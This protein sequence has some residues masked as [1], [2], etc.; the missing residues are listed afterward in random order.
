MSTHEP[1]ELPNASTGWSRHLARWRRSLNKP[2]RH[3][4]ASVAHGLQRLA[5]PLTVRWHWLRAR[6]APPRP[7]G[8]PGELVLSLTS[9]PGR[10][11]VLHLTLMSLLGQ[12]VKP[13]HVVL[14]VDEA[15]ADLVPPKVRSLQDHGLSIRTWPQDIKS[16]MKIIPSLARWPEATFVTA[17]DDICYWPTWLEELLA[18]SAHRPGHV[19]CH[20]AHRVLRDDAGRLRA[21]RDWRWSVEEPAC[22]DD[23]FFT[24]VGGVL[25]P[26]GSLQ[27][28]AA[29]GDRYR[30]L[31]PHGDDIWLNWMTRLQGYGVFTTGRGQRLVSWL[32]SQ[33]SGLYRH[34]VRGHGNDEAL[35]HMTQVYGDLLGRPPTASTPA[36]A[37]SCA[38][39]ASMTAL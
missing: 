16:Y 25:Y 8:L 38:R 11:P 37:A 34:N 35:Q 9:F 4:L 14:W 24:G 17:D 32:G 19:V 12:T 22:G 31:A 29:E 20:R 27:R 3:K 2:W 10:F 1:P 15:Y 33:R 23:L 28:C 39:M 5:A 13:D 30:A 26:A 6:H 7:H 18:A 36:Q 21:Y